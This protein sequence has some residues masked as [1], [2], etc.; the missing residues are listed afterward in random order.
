MEVLTEPSK[1]VLFSPLSNQYFELHDGII[2]TTDRECLGKLFNTPH[3]LESAV[4]EV[5]NRDRVSI[6]IECIY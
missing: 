1:F 5:K 3:S 4:T 2:C 6:R